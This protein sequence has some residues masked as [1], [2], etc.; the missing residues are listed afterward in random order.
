MFAIW[1]T[2]CAYAPLCACWH[3]QRFS[4]PIYDGSSHHHKHT[5]SARYLPQVQPL[6]LEEILESPDHGNMAT[7]NKMGLHRRASSD[8]M[9]FLE[10]FYNSD[11]MAGCFAAEEERYSA[12][13]GAPPSVH[14]LRIEIPDYNG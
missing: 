5:P 4:F 7:V 3:D 12:Q 8:S 10:S 11:I 9:A 2:I 14:T 13:G 6:W 1:I